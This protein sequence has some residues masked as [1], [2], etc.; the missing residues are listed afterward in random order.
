MFFFHFKLQHSTLSAMIAGLS[1]I[2]WVLRVLW[3]SLARRCPKAGEGITLCHLIFAFLPTCPAQPQPPP[4]PPSPLLYSHNNCAVP[5]YGPLLQELLQQRCHYTHALCFLLHMHSRLILLLM[6]Q[7]HSPS[8]RY[9]SSPADLGAI[10]I[11]SITTPVI[12]H[13]IFAKGHRVP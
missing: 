2:V 12:I 8:S 10:T 11:T 9:F 6:Y 1:S 7:H 5:P 13:S 4:L 3:S